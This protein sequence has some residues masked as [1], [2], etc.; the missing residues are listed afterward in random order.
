MLAAKDGSSKDAAP[1]FGHSQY[2]TSPTR[3]TDSIKEIGIVD[4]WREFNPT[5]RYYTYFSAPQ[6]TY[7]RIDYFFAFKR[8]RFR[9]QLC[10]IGTIYMS[11]HAQ[12]VMKVNIISVTQN[13]HYGK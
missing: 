6:S 13:L 5:G 1:E 9:I 4:V 10:D 3:R 7:S 2:S 8:E 12:V 11:D